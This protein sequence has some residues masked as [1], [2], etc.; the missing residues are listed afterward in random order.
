MITKNY[1]NMAKLVLT[2]DF[3]EFI[4]IIVKSWLPTKD[5]FIYKDFDDKWHENREHFIYEIE[6]INK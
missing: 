4:T 6:Y 3:K 5:G 1:P 2:E